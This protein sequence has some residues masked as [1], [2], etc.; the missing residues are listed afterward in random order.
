MRY[1]L[2]YFSLIWARNLRALTG[3]L[4][5]K[6]LQICQLL[7]RLGIMSSLLFFF[8]KKAFQRVFYDRNW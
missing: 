3:I 7:A 2:N 5:L 4:A 8:L 1:F 6:K